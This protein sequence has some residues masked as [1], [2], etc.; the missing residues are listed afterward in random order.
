MAVGFNIPNGAFRLS[1]EEAGGQPDYMKALQ[2]GFQGAAD[3]YKPSQMA[4]DLLKQQLANKF[5]QPRSDRAE[6]FA[7]SDLD[8]KKA[9]GEAAKM[10]LNPF[11]RLSGVARDAYSIETLKNQLGEENPA[12]LAAK[13]QYDLA[14]PICKQK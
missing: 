12:Y 1:A 14:F 13:S 9:L 2:Q 10:G 11:N 6:E 4:A 5:Q 7:Q 3:V 8:Y